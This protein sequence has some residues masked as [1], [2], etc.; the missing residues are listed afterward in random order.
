MDHR[1]TARDVIVELARNMVEGLEPLEYTTLAPNHFEVYLHQ[2]DYQALEPLFPEIRRE[3]ALKLDDEVKRLNE[4][5]QQAAPALLAWLRPRTEPDR[6]VERRGDAWSIKFHVD[7]EPTAQPGDVTVH[8]CF[9][10]NEQ[11]QYGVGTTTRRLRGT[12]TG[13]VETAPATPKAVYARLTY[14]DDRG[15]H[16]YEVTKESVVIGRRD[17]EGHGGYWADV[18]LDTRT[19]VSREH[20]RIRRDAA[21]G[22]FFIKDVSRFGTT[23]NGTPLPPS[24]QEVD[25]E[26]KDLDL[27]QPL[28]NQ[29]QIELAGI[30]TLHFEAL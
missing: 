22:T 28:P 18:A 5:R 11:R 4:H 17:A 1:L 7:P 24:F 9:T 27:W 29:A 14:T 8:S 25:G 21:T 15:P 13:K 23:V 19:D 16:T 20:V 26:R 6:P 2:Q 10:A 30:L 12:Q 3:A